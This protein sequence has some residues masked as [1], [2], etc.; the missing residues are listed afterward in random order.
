MAR[1][2]YIEF[3]F[4]NEDQTWRTEVHPCPT[5]DPEDATRWAC[6]HL[7]LMNDEFHVMYFALA[8]D[9]DPRFSEGKE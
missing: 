3:L 1:T 2:N 9:D 4:L 5:N 8:G 6:T 7:H